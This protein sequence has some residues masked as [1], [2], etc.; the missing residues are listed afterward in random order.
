MQNF[1][2][3]L[4]KKAEREHKKFPYAFDLEAVQRST[5]MGEFDDAYIA[6]IYNFAGNQ[7]RS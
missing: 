1:L 2:S 3:T 6:A 7:M 5:S 4:K